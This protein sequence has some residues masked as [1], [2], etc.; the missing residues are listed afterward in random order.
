MCVMRIRGP[1]FYS[2]G[3]C[4]VCSEE[5]ETFHV[6]KQQ[7]FW[8][9]RNNKK[10]QNTTRWGF[11]RNGTTY[12]PKSSLALSHYCHVERTKILLFVFCKTA[13]YVEYIN[14]EWKFCPAR[15]PKENTTA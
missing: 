10:K 1:P 5:N 6:Y 9:A 15:N 2:E 12:Y 7:K 13:T 4:C 8:P 11:V 3:Y 14:I